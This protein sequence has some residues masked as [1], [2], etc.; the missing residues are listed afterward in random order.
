MAKGTFVQDGQHLDYT[1]SGADASAGDIVLIGTRI[2][3]VVRDTK[4]GK[5]GALAVSGVW[6]MPKATGQ[7]WTLGA[8]IYW[9][10]G[11]NN[12]TTTSAGNTLVGYAA[13]AAALN[14]ATGLVRI[15]AK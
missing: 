1:P 13:K 7:S 14:D 15:N 3:V 12:F 10:A 11:A 4:D 9:D 8:S 6:E 2:G 5:L